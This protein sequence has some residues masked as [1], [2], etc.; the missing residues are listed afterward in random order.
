VLTADDCDDTAATGPGFGAIAL[1]VD[2]DGVLT[3]D[4]C[5]DTAATGA[6]FGAFAL[7]V[8]C[9]GVVTADDCDDTAATGAG[10]GAF[11][12]DV[13]CDGVVTAV[14]CDDDDP[15]TVGDMDCDGVMTAADCDDSDPTSTV[16]ATDADCDGVLTLFDCDDNDPGTAND[17]DC[18]G[19][20]TVDD[21]DDRWL[22]GSPAAGQGALSTI[23]ADD[24]DC[25]GVL[26]ADDCNDFWAM[27]TVVAEDADCDGVLTPDDCNDDD[28]WLLAIAADLDC[29]GVAT[30]LDCDDTDVHQGVLCG[31]FLT[32]GTFEM[33][34]TVGDPSCD[35]DESP[36]HS[37]TLAN[38]FWM[39]ETEVTQEK[40]GLVMG[41]NPSIFGPNGPNGTTCLDCPV[42]NVNWYEAMAFANEVSS[43]EALAECYTLSFPPAPTCQGTPGAPSPG[44]F[45]CS[46]AVVNSPVGSPYD[47]EGYRLPTEAEWEYAARAG[48]DD[49]SLYSGSDIIGDV[50]WYG[51]NGGNTTHAVA[52]KDPNDWG[53]YDMSGNV[54]EWTWDQYD[55]TYYSNSPNLD[56]QGPASGSYFRVGR[57]GSWLDVASDTRVANR[58]DVATAS[59][60]FTQ[61]FRLVRTSMLGTFG[62]PAASCLSVLNDGRFTVDGT[63]WIDPDG[64]GLG[65]FE[66]YCDMTTDGG[67]WLLVSTQQ[68]DG[69]LSSSAASA[70]V[71]YNYSLASNQKYSNA[72][73]QQLADLG[74]YQVMVEENSGADRDAGLVMVYRLP[75]G[76]GLRF[77]TGAVAVATI[78]WYI[79]GGQYH[80]VTNN[81]GGEGAPG[82]CW[83]GI[84]VHS[85]SAAGDAWNGLPSS[86]RCISKN[87]FSVTNGSN[88]DYKLD[89]NGTHSGTTRCIHGIT[90]IGISHWIR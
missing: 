85:S 35:S 49:D 6:G 79:G 30:T 12:L 28:P 37:V 48:T 42:E 36:A 80:T 11:A 18:D 29:D 57:G 26:T 2:C 39:S 53:L 68:P 24:A 17:M 70:N 76:T 74:D 32:S 40:W 55:S 51:S 10:F 38:N 7:D 65:A 64:D 89:H 22:N 63:Y 67:G 72:V 56:P 4:D 3:A 83:W 20:L 21:C 75:Q 50:A 47:C 14:D 44:N 66:A 58:A 31:E 87:D 23:V 15:T 33:G 16:I 59:L 60:S 19:H 61:G 78:D 81:Q 8:D 84:S 71:V 41:N 77:D 54:G 73:L 46:D 5:D 86:E 45:I 43:A 9:D 27:S 13:D 88:G 1:D 25:D 52:S 69:L 90:G 82:C 62:N 34:C